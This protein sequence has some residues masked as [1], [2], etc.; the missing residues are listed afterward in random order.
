MPDDD[1][2][3]DPE[4]PAR[5]GLVNRLTRLFSSDDSGEGSASTAVVNGA[6]TPTPSEMRL[7]VGEFEQARVRDVMIPR[8][9]ISAVDIDMPLGELLAYFAEH[10]HSRVPVY[11]GTL[12]DPAAQMPLR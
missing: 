8:I 4:S 9:E 2:A 3:I 5:G 1:S 7:R 12:D 10:A 6:P 11:R